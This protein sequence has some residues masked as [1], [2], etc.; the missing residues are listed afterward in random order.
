MATRA[1]ADGTQKELTAGYTADFLANRDS[2]KG[3]ATLEGKILSDKT[4]DP[5]RQNM[6]AGRVQ[7]RSDILERRISAFQQ[8][9]DSVAATDEMPLQLDQFDL[10]D[11]KLSLVFLRRN[12]GLVLLAVL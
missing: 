3:L 9:Q 11:T 2:L 5:T 1:V 8:H 12:C 10:Q 6:L 4:L 7:A